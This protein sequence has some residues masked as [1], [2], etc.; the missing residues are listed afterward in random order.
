MV[1]YVWVVVTHASF[2]DET[3]FEPTVETGELSADVFA[4][5]ADAEELMKLSPELRH[6]LFTSPVVK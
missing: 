5:L 6:D 3:T 4:S 1:Q 2:L